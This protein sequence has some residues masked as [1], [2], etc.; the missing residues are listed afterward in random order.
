MPVWIKAR[1][2]KWLLSRQRTAWATVHVI[3]TRL[4][5]NV[6]FILGFCSFSV[7]YRGL[8]RIVVSKG[9]L[10]VLTTECTLSISS[11]IGQCYA[12]AVPLNWL[13]STF[14][15]CLKMSSI[16]TQTG[17]EYGGVSEVTLLLLPLQR[18]S[19]RYPISTDWGFLCV[20]DRNRHLLYVNILSLN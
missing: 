17:E 8:E 12:Y 15:G 6:Q 11:S 7:T 5:D 19:K 20:F 16:I 14:C 3:M 18:S 1:W 13:R 4:S 10:I 9:V 2:T